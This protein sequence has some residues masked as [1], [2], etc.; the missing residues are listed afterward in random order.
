MRFILENP[1]FAS[2]PI[3]IDNETA[4]RQ[5][6]A[7]IN[8]SIMLGDEIIIGINDVPIKLRIVDVNDQEYRFK[9]VKFKRL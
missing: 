9:N 8:K 3:E 6:A 4:I 1:S 2:E 7:C 5:I